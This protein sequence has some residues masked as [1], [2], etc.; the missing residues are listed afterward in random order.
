MSKEHLTKLQDHLAKHN[1]SL[2]Q[3]VK[4]R[5]RML[6]INERKGISVEVLN[7]E[8]KEIKIYTSILKAAKAIGC[9][10][11]TILLAEKTLLEKGINR[12]VKK[13]F[14]VKVIRS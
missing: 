6:K 4:A 9:V 8:T 11:G 14:M 3:R 5:E 13:K 10:D 7:L 2:E 1:A 12:P